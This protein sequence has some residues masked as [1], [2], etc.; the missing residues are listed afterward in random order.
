MLPRVFPPREH[1]REGGTRLREAHGLDAAL[2]HARHMFPQDFAAHVTT[3]SGMF[4]GAERRSS[5]DSSSEW[6]LFFRQTYRDDLSLLKGVEVFFQMPS[7]I[8]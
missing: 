7:S 6:T 8:S 5:G 3:A 4:G 2:P 1:Q